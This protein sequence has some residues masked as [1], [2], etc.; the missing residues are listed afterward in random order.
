MSDIAQRLQETAAQCLSSL[1]AWQK[2]IKNDATREQLMDAVHELRK[3]ASRL[4]IDIALG[5]R[6]NTNAK[7]IPIPEHKSK[8]E[9]RT[10]QKPL[11]EILPVAEIREKRRKRIE[12]ENAREDDENGDDSGDDNNTA[13]GNAPYAGETDGPEDAG[14]EEN[15]PAA[16]NNRRPRRQKREEKNTSGR[17]DNP[18]EA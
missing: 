14:Q 7:R 18:S 17:N 16:R 2:D 15:R 3:V 12:I 8:M 9:K 10:D 13:G 4:E 6:A 1:A 11:S 5:E